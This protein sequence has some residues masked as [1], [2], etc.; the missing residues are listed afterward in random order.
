MLHSDGEESAA[1]EEGEMERPVARLHGA[2]KT[3]HRTRPR[4]T[5]HEHCMRASINSSS[6]SA[7]SI[8]SLVHL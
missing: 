1:A 2:A 4:L 3:A 8:V 5:V 7:A 6:F